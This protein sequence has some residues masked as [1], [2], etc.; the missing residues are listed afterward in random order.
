MLDLND[1]RNNYHR[2]VLE[3][4]GL[5]ADPLELFAQWYNQA[6]NAGIYDANAMVLS[7]IVDNAP[8]SRVVLLKEATYKGFVFFTNYQSAKGLA[9]AQNPLVA[10]NFYW[11]EA[12]KQVRIEGRAEKIPED[13]S[14]AYFNSRP[15]QSRI[16]A[17]VSPQSKSISS[18]DDLVMA[19]EKHAKES[20]NINRPAHWG[21]YCVVPHMIEFWQGRPDRLHD[22]IRYSVSADKNWVLGRLAP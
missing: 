2:S 21:G 10:L 8:S 20:G 3:D 6:E 1:K 12:E 4:A 22:R 15:L 9:I 14:D 5:P 16:S 17:I 11:R 13:E 18:R 19:A 7:T